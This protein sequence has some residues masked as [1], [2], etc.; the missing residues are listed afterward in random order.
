MAFLREWLARY[1]RGAGYLGLVSPEGSTGVH[2]WP[3]GRFVPEGAPEKLVIPTLSLTRD[4]L[5]RWGSGVEA[6]L[7]RAR[8]YREAFLGSA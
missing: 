8:A 1:V 2:E 4:S 3:D 5:A 7:A 6:V